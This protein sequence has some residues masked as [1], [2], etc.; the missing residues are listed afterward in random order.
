MKVTEILAAAG[1]R[2]AELT[3]GTLPVHSPIDGAEVAR[4]AETRAD[5]M[6]R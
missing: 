6:G 1:L 2:D 5:E 4:V 3:G